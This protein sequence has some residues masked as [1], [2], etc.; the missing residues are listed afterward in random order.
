MPVYNAEAYL[1]ECID[2]IIKQS[3]TNWELIAVDDQSTDDSLS[4]LSDYSSKNSNIKIHT[5]TNKGIIPALHEAFIQ[6]NGVLITRMDADDIMHVDKLLLL[7]NTLLKSG[8]GHLATAFVRYFSDSKL[9]D[10]Y[11]KYENWLNGLT[12]QEINF[13]EIYKECVIPSPCWMCYRSDLQNCDAFNPQTYPED[14]DLCFRF[15]KVGLKVIAVRQVLHYWRDHSHRSSRNDP[16]YSDN[17]FLNLK[18]QYFLEDDFDPIKK[19]VLWGAGR[20]G[21]TIAKELIKNNIPFQWLT[22][23]TEKIDKQIYGVVLQNDKKFEFT[24][25][26]QVIIAV[27]QQNESNLIRTRMANEKQK[28]EDL[29][30]FFF[31]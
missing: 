5:T 9:G 7:S 27:A 1:F 26:H 12:N 13:T 15:R 28:S 18:M 22:N 11:T 3:Y 25:S 4:I 16:N 17:S 14:Y 20:K 30:V 21:K 6:S 10:G 31:C 23:N 2:S 8:R 24:N 19:M 29:K